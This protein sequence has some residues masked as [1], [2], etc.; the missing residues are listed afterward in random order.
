[1]YENITVVAIHGNGG[2]E[3]LIPA[4]NKSADA[5][6]GSKRLLITD[7]KLYTEIPHKYVYRPFGYQEYSHFVV[8]CLHQYIDTDYCLIVQDD[9]WVL[10]ADNWKDSWLKYDY[11]GGATHAA[12]EGDQ[13]AIWYHWEHLF[14]NP[15]VVQNGGFS[16]RSRRFLRAPSLYGITM[17]ILDD[18]MMNNEDIQLCCF[19]RPALES[20]GVKFAP[21]EESVLFSF[22][23]LS[24]NL[25]KDVD[26]KKVFGHHSRFRKLTGDNQMKWLMPDDLF[27]QI[28]R[29]DEVLDLFKH[30]NYEIERA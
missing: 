8:Y 25:H 5:L 17:R 4:L 30:Y 14:K 15:L 1:M 24:P 6:P 18:P 10:N 23:H 7:T 9:G 2:G 22:E 19:M 12:L 3:S 27:K 21:L 13:F 29:E 26:L 20:V 28:P 16:L 11:I